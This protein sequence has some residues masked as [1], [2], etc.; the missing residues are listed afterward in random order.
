MKIPWK[1]QNIPRFFA[2]HRNELGLF[3]KGLIRKREFFCF[4]KWHLTTWNVNH[5]CQLLF[6]MDSM[7]QPRLHRI[8]VNF[9]QYVR[10]MPLSLIR[11][12]CC[13]EEATLLLD[14]NVSARMKYNMSC[15]RCKSL[16][17]LCCCVIC[18]CKTFRKVLDFEKAAHASHV[19]DYEKVTYLIR[20]WVSY[21]LW[22]IQNKKFSRLEIWF[23]H[24][25]CSCRRMSVCVW[26]C[27]YA[28]VV[29]RWQHRLTFHVY[30]ISLILL[31]LF[32]GVAL[33]CSTGVS[34]QILNLDIALLSPLPP[35]KQFNS[36]NRAL[37]KLYLC[38]V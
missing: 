24:V 16:L 23:E 11:N 30:I 20:V 31:N 35:Q 21:G 14:A 2:Q 9:E 17:C 32:Y 6:R 18:C 38:I 3:W 36:V 25:Q 26:A 34:N 37:S 28:D 12:A 15:L 4:F 10:K 5:I 7:N 27:V 1:C 33:F 22:I 19:N 8:K 13:L 29:Y